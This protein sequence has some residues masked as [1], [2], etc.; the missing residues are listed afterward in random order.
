LNAFPVKGILIELADVSQVRRFQELREMLIDNLFTQFRNDLESV[1][2]ATDMLTGIELPPDYKKETA[3]LLKGKVRH[4][5]GTLEKVQLRLAGELA[6]EDEKLFPV[7][8]VDSLEQAVRNLEKEQA[9]RR[10]SVKMR[11]PRLASLVMASPDHFVEMFEGILF[12]LLRD[13]AEQTSVCVEGEE[14]EG[15]IT[16]NFSNTGFGIPRERFQSYM[17][18]ASEATS[19]EFRD[20]R[21]SLQFIKAWGGE[22]VAESTTGEGLRVMV[23]LDVFLCQN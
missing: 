6:P 19:P 23:K 21:R 17:L 5:V 18:D 16:L 3:A 11:L 1:V 22:A 15:K 10:V 8:I 14:K 4:M 9:E 7:S 2:L 20:L 13:A 12:A